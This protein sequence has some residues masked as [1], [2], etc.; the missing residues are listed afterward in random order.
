MAGTAV[1]EKMP[2][3]SVRPNCSSPHAI[4]T[5]HGAATAA[6]H[7][8]ETRPRPGRRSRSRR[9]MAGDAQERRRCLGQNV[10]VYI[11]EESAVRSLRVE[12]PDLDEPVGLTVGERPDQDG[13]DQT[14]GGDGQTDSGGQR[15][16]HRRQ[17]A[18]GAQQPASRHQAAKPVPAG[19]HVESPLES[20]PTGSAR[21]VAG[22]VV[23]HRRSVF[24]PG[25]DQDRPFDKS[26]ATA[27]GTGF[28]VGVRGD[29]RESR[30]A[31][32][33]R[34][35][36]APRARPGPSW[37][38]ARHAARRRRADRDRRAASA[39]RP[40]GLRTSARARR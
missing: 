2:L 19:P 25:D 26:T 22:L 13:V 7:G 30:G 35:R 20:P 10:H 8:A 27:V 23:G 37:R 17:L 31:P 29:P 3:S 9:A 14:V 40:A 33:A 6:M 12:V 21:A 28:V 34:R 1:R 24:R 16:R 15:D 39:R 18:R 32:P 4:S 36:S 11:P 38:T 5:A